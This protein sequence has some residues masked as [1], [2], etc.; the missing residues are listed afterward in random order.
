MTNRTTRLFL[1]RLASGSLVASV[2]AIGFASTGQAQTLGPVVQVAGAD[3]FT[4]CTKD[5]VGQQETAFGSVLFPNT[6]IE[7]WVA[8]DPTDTSRLL[9]GHQQDRWSDGGA[10]GDIGVVSTD[11]GST[12]TNPVPPIPPDVTRCVGGKDDRA[13]DPWV[14]FANDGTALFMSLVVNPAKPSTPFGARHSG[15]LASRSADHG[16]TWSAPV[17][18]T[19]NNSPHVLNDKNSMTADPTKNGLVYAVWDQ[20]S[21]FPPT[22][23]GAALLAQNDGVAIARELLHSAV[24][25]SSVCAPFTKPPCKGGA[26]FF[27]FNFSGPTLLA[28]STNNGVG[29]ASPATIVNT[30]PG[31]QTI[32]NLVQVTPDGT[33]YDFFTAINFTPAVLNIGFVKSTNKGISWSGPAFA[34]DIQVVGVVSPDTGQA[35]RDASILYAVSVNPVSGAIYLTWQDD[36]FS[37]TSCIT[38]GTP[39]PGIPIDGIVFSQS[40]DGGATWSKPVMINK[41]PA[42][43]TNPCRQQAFIPA[44]VA[45]GDGKTVVVTYYD[46]RNDTNT[47]AGFEGTDYF[48]IFCFTTTDCTNPANWVNEQRLTTTSFNILN[49]PVAGGHFLGD[50]MGLA[51]SGPN[52]VYPVFG[53][54][55]GVN[56]TADFTRSISGLP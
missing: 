7:P 41:T 2:C 4:S 43:A 16:Q 50:Y 55:T 5:N 46:F 12:W 53:Q 48:A 28:L 39:S 45:T 3:P 52:T 10:R 37:T 33:V 54:A 8:V 26:P 9:V 11:G 6:S 17:A 47:P 51:A 56:T 42:N 23:A 20:L 14:V 29:F 40:L 19:T 24:G 30:G 25:N 21:V 22:D 15:M 49:A 36:R 31:Q 44:L 32:D 34:T 38:P 35:L 27:K 1:R 18:L 13:S